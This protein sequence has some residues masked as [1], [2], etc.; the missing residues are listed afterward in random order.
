[1]AAVCGT[2]AKRGC[3]SVSAAK[4][5]PLRATDDVEKD[6]FDG[7]DVKMDEAERLHARLPYDETRPWRTSLN[8][9]PGSRT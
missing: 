7:T 4:S 6:R 1:M 9:D 8:S 2:D 5:R 3:V